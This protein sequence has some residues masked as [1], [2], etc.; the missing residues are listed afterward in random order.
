MQPVWGK[1]MFKITKHQGN[2]NKDQ[3]EITYTHQ[4]GSFKKNRKK[5]IVDEG[6][7]TLKPLCT[8]GE[9]LKLYSH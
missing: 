2:A 9:N 6:V 5:K 7:E 8:A 1:K 3:N 4:A